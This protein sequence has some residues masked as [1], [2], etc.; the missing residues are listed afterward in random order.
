M[1]ILSSAFITFLT[2]HAPFTPYK[3]YIIWR[4]LCLFTPSSSMNISKM[5]LFG[6]DYYF[7]PITTIIFVKRCAN[8]GRCGTYGRITTTF[9]IKSLLA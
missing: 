4:L 9:S 6:Y 1:T 7:F 5:F 8:F 3:M 2:W